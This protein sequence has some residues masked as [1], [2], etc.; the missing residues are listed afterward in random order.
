MKTRRLARPIARTI[1][2]HRER[3]RTVYRLA[4]SPPASCTDKLIRFLLH[5][6][7]S[8]GA[9]SCHHNCVILQGIQSFPNRLLNGVEVSAPEISP[10]D[11]APKECVAGQDKIVARKMKTHGSG[12]VA[13]RMEGDSE[14]RPHHQL[15]FILQPV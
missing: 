14:N 1:R 13:R 10:P 12:G 7:F 9:M 15:L 8:F 2:I 5:S 4:W 6:D 11:A 3:G